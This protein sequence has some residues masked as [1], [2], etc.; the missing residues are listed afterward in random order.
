M[1]NDAHLLGYSILIIALLVSTIQATRPDILESNR[2]R[3]FTMFCQSSPFL[4]LSACFLTESTSLRLVSDY[5]GQGLPPLYRISAVWGSRAGPLLMWASFMGLISWTMS[6]EN[7]PDLL[8]IRVM[9][10][11][12][13]M[14]LLVSSVLRP[15][16]PSLVGSSGGD[17]SSPTDQPDGH[18]PSSSFCLLLT[19]P[20]NCECRGVWRIE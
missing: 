14:I 7:K 5:V 17:Q 11:W 1:V 9:H 19:L 2:A 16:S 8:S 3:I 10:G 15:F 20:R 18:S 13:A 12:T 4:F 6:R